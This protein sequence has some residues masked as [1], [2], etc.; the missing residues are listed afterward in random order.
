MPQIQDIIEKVNEYS[1]LHP[2]TLLLLPQHRFLLDTNFSTLGDWPI[3]HHLLWLVD[4]DSAISVTAL[5][6]LGTLTPQITTF[7]R[8][9]LNYLAPTQY[10]IPPTLVVGSGPLS[11][12]LDIYDTVDMLLHATALALR[13][14]RKTEAMSAPS[15]VHPE[16]R[17]TPLSSLFC[18]YL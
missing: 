9:I 7:S 16:A 3:S 12:Y 4:M 2:V 8:K 1:L 15:D 5:A 17:L 11:R 13:W 6:Q 10:C 18:F 14:K